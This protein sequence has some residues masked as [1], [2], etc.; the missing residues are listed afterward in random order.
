MPEC[1]HP[2]VGVGTFVMRGNKFL[3][4]KRKGSH[5]SGSWQLP[6]GKLEFGESFEDCAKREVL[7]ETNLEITNVIYQTTTNDVMTN[8]NMHYVGIFMRAEVVDMGADPLV[9][10][11]NKCECW[12]WVTWDEF[13]KGGI[14]GTENIQD[15]KINKY[16]PMFHPMESLIITRNGQKPL[17]AH[18]PTQNYHPAVLITGTSVGIGRETAFTLAKLGYT[19]FA[20]V[21]KKDDADDLIAAFRECDN[22]KEGCLNPII[23]DVTNKDHIQNAYDHIQSTIGHEIPFVGLINNAALV[24]YLP[25]EI[26]SD[27]AFLNSFNTNYFSIVNLTKKFLPLLRESGGRVINMGS[28]AAWENSAIMGIYSATKA[29]V[30]VMTRI[31]RMETKEMDVHF[32]LIEPGIIVSRLNDQTTSNFRNFKSFSSLS[33]YYSTSQEANSKVIVEYEKLYKAV[34]KCS[35]NFRASPTEIAADAILHALTA[36]YPKNTYYV[37][38]DAKVLASVN[39][40]L[41]D[42]VAETV[43]SKV[44]SFVS[45]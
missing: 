42:R 12:E 29:A 45:N 25:M 2:L 22:P 24:V 31:W 13:I 32:A 39:W 28:I 44:L 27:D 6:G 35:E 9:M 19:V 23:L 34:A 41:G 33:D 1:T 38:L 11:P 21:R 37:G 15:G 36:P 18:V 30:R 7:E 26:A 4:G 43:Q 17:K 3:I 10:E 16:R 20:G 8:E 40:L 14:T 5:G